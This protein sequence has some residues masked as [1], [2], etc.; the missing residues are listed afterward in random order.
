M[1]RRIVTLVL[2]VAVAGLEA[3]SG[4]FSRL[5]IGARAVT[6]GGSLITFGDDPN[7][8]FYN[9]SGI[10]TIPSL[11][12]ST[13][14]TQL[15]TGISGDQLKYFSGSATVNL[16][17]IGTLGAGAKVFT[18]NAWKE[19]E[20]YGSYARSLYFDWL[21]VGGSVK[22]LH[23]SVP[24]PAGRLA[25]PEPALSKATLS[26]DVGAQAVLENIFPNNDVRVGAAIGDITRPSIAANGAKTG[27]LERKYSAGVS[28][29]SRV[30]DYAVILHYTVIGK[31]KR[32]GVGTEFVALKTTLLGEEMR[33]L[34]RV[35]GGMEPRPG[36]QGDVDGGFG[37]KAAGLALDYA[38]THQTQLLFLSGTHHLSLH[39]SL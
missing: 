27:R 12:F 39:Y 20:F 36:R 34:V 8:L 11:S 35:G 7:V 37:L 5:P 29:A 16:D 24:A 15:L 3:F 30:Y 18:S 9:P 10:A 33:F 6:M 2:M 23:W 21:L 28:Y 25:V 14:Y 19:N 17:F 31:E 22:L 38:Y 1:K 32:I 4:G 13:S 26:F